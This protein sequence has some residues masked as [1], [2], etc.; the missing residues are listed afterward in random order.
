[1]KTYI[2]IIAVIIALFT[3]KVSQSSNNDIDLRGNWKFS[4]GDN[5]E[6]ASPAFNDN[7]WELMKVPARWE[8][9]GYQGYNGYAWYR[10]SCFIPNNFDE[11]IVY[12]ELGY[13]DDV[14]E[15][16]FNGV[17][18]G[19]SGS[20]PPNFETA[21]NAFRKYIIP[22]KLIKIG[23]KNHIAVRTYDVQLEG[24][25]VRGNVQL[26]AGDITVH[27]DIDMSG[28]WNFET[29]K[30]GDDGETILVPGKWENQGYFDYNGI[31]SYTR[32]F[33]ISSEMLKNRYIFMA[34]RIDDDDMFYVN[35][36]FVAQT[37]DFNNRHNTNM[38]TEYR[39]Y[40]IPDGLL[41]EGKNIIEIKVIDRGG[42][43]GIL[44]GAIGLITQDRFIE[45][46]NRKRYER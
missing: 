10:T 22:S 3:A 36:V 46:W 37:G 28:I 13:I 7:D 12:L 9:Q 25:I 18:V 23:D 16:Y 31:V 20:F 24:G 44:E 19:Q 38:H 17:K 1:M 41:K 33:S 39:N 5:Q 15:L 43:G 4:I 34:G 26:V 32:E 29:N 45:Y 8:E 21:Y 11:R 27:P 30:F 14:D 42:E 35:G 40:F 6:W 2:Q